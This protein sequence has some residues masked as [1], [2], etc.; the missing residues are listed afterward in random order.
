MSLF[1]DRKNVFETVILEKIPDSQVHIEDLRG[2]G[3][4]YSVH[5]ISPSFEGKSRIEQHKMVYTALDELMAGALY[6]L[7]LKTGIIEK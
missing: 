7:S 3:E 5:V 6:T 1:E 2:D 4:H